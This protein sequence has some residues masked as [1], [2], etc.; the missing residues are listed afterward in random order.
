MSTKQ[1]TP[2]EAIRKMCIWCMGGHPKEVEECRAEDCPLHPFRLN[3][4]NQNKNSQKNLSG[5]GR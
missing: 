4:Q 5:I 2:K 1:L 3:G